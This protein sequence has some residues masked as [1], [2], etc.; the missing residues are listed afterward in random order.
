MHDP[1][2]TTLRYASLRAREMWHRTLRAVQRRLMG[3]R[4]LAWIALAEARARLQ[5]ASRTLAWERRVFEGAVPSVRAERLGRLEQA[6]GTIA[7][8]RRRVDRAQVA[9]QA[10]AR[11]LPSRPRPRGARGAVAEVAVSEDWAVCVGAA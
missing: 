1:T 10:A 9:L 7:A 3:E 4:G 5:V 11:T 2:S 6:R 8:A